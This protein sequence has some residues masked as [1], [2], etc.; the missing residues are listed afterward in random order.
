MKFLYVPVTL[1]SEGTGRQG[2]NMATRNPKLTVKITHTIP[3]YQF[4]RHF[5]V[6]LPIHGKFVE[7][8]LPSPRIYLY[9]V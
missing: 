4:S 3:I 2:T 8:S 6:H 9:Q 1:S 7:I 5:L